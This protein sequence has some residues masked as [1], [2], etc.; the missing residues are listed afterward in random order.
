MN[1]YST[2]VYNNYGKTR[3][4]V[5]KDVGVQ[6]FMP[7]DEVVYTGNEF[8]SELKGRFGTIAARVHGS[9]ENFVVDYGD[10]A[11]VFHWTLL[12]H[13]RPNNREERA[14]MEQEVV[15]RRKRKRDEDES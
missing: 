9:Q 1:K 4:P 14:K 8:R 3:V 7:F 12:D 6:R 10:D 5:T 15:Y 2:I 13:Y 11:Y